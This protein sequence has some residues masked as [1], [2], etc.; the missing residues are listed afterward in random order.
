[1]MM[2]KLTEG[3]S[4]GKCWDITVLVIISMVWVFLWLPGLGHIQ[5]CR[6]NLRAFDTGFIC[7]SAIVYYISNCALEVIVQESFIF[8]Q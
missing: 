3:T 4:Y 8:H 5:G 1:M 6:P 7:G 2:Y